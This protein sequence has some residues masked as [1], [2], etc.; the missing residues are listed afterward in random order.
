[1][2]NGFIVSYF[3]LSKVTANI[4]DLHVSFTWSCLTIGLI[5]IDGNEFRLSL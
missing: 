3:M 1:M 4:V 5:T 2:Q